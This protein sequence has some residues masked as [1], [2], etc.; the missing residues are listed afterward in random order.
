MNIFGPDQGFA[1]FLE[2]LKAGE[3]R[4]PLTPAMERAAFVPVLPG[5]APSGGQNM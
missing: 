2:S 5:T 1:G 4:S 3:R